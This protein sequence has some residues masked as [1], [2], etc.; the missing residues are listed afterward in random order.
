MLLRS[1]SHAELIRCGMPVF[2]ASEL[3]LLFGQAPAVEQDFAS[4]MADFYVNFISDLHPG[5]DLHPYR[6]CPPRLTLSSLSAPWPQY[7]LA[8]KSVLQLMRD[9]IT[10]IPDGTQHL[11][12]PVCSVTDPEA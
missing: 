7:E 3:I 2:H 5:G 9:N 10:A 8:T 12:L 11:R 4:Q 1:L 6:V